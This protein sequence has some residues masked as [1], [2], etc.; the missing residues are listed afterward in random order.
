MP[1]ITVTTD[2]GLSGPY[3]AEMKGVILSINPRASIVDIT[4]LIEPQ[5]I[6]QAS[7]IISLAYPHF[8]DDSI[9]LVVVDPGVGSSRRALILKTP[10]G[11][12][13]A[14][15]NGVLSHIV[16]SFL[17]NFSEKDS[18]FL[19]GNTLE[20]VNIT[21]QR[22]WHHPVSATFHG[23]DI[24]AP[25]AA[26]LSLGVP[27]EACGEKIDSLKV[28]PIPEVKT[29]PGYI[30]GH[31][32]C[33]DA[34]GNLITDVKADYISNLSGIE[35]HIGRHGIKGPVKTYAEGEGLVFLEG[36]HGFLEI[37]LVNGNAR[38]F[39]GANVGDEVIIKISP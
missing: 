22:Y 39:S 33:I 37:A 10:Q 16:R 19:S 28:L 36:S 32:A 12:F 5:N 3:V 7:L 13:V 27:M 26:Y 18:V 20:A 23:R 38:E 1:V 11:I 14:P 2:F 34:F 4:H 6:F 21:N 31:V 17:G 29:Y 25:V 8:P 24:F 15:D 30:I 9:H 35:V